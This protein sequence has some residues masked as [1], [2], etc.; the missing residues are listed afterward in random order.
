MKKNYFLLAMFV[1]MIAACGDD[2]NGD[3]TNVSGNSFVPQVLQDIVNSGF[4]D[5]S[6]NNIV[7]AIN[8]QVIISY[9]D[10]VNP[11]LVEPW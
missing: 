5:T 4:Y 9:Q 1:M 8:S 2:D 3:I 11:N 7:M 6:T 10:I